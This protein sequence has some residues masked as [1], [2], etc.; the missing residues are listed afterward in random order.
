[1]ALIIDPSTVSL[2]RTPKSQ[3]DENKTMQTAELWLMEERRAILRVVEEVSGSAEDYL[4][5][6]GSLWLAVPET[7]RLEAFKQ[8]EQSL[9]VK[10]V[11]NLDWGSPEDLTAPYRMTIAADGFRN[12][13]GAEQSVYAFVP[14]TMPQAA[15]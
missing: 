8:F 1:M 7:R 11:G 5:A 15:S 2:V 6:V 14:E 12:A 10:K 9:R 4:R 3:A 13:G